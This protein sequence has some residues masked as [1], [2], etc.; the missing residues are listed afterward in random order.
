MKAGRAIHRLA[1]LFRGPGRGTKERGHVL[2]A[3]TGRAGTTFFVRICTRLGLDTGFSEK[4]IA[5]AEGNVGRAGLERRI[6]RATI[7]KLPE[8]I[9]SP[10]VVDVLDAGLRE[11]WLAVDCAIIPVRELTAAAASRRAVSER[12]AVLGQNP[13]D[14]PGGLWKTNDP[15][16][17]EA[18]LAVQF[19]KVVEALV[20][21]DV[22]ILFLSFPRFAN[23]PDYLVEVLGD[24]FATRFGVDEAA[25]RAAH[26][27]EVRPELIG[28]HTS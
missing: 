22:P 2:I 13:N 18:V 26:A 6:T 15:A 8:I 12:A 23:E 10:H 5:A 19:Y 3:G 7:A 14:A 9:K 17:Q 27:A 1:G 28:D 4:H 25:L 24:F 21:H 11:G 16:A 20:A